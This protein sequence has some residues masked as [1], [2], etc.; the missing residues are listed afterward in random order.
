[1]RRWSTPIA[2]AALVTGCGITPNS[3]VEKA[4]PPVV[5]MQPPSTHIWLVKRGRLEDVPVSTPKDHV[6]GLLAKLFDA[7][8]EP[9]PDDETSTHLRGFTLDRTYTER[10]PRDPDSLP[11]TETLT[12]YIKGESKLTRLAKA[13]IVC[14]AQQDS[15]IDRVKIVRIS[16]NGPDRSEGSNNCKELQ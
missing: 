3:A 6:E 9:M 1:M 16:D 2:L 12:V 7:S 15:K 11:R 5:T 4:P 10:A 8:K 14:T 13:Q